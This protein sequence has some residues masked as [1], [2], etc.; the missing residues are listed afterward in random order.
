[1]THAASLALS[2]AH[3]YSNCRP[4]IHASCTAGG[5]PRERVRR[6]VRV[7]IPHRRHPN[8]HQDTGPGP[9]EGLPMIPALY[10]QWK[11]ELRF[12]DWTPC[13]KLCI[14]A[15]SRNWRYA[16]SHRLKGP[17][18]FRCTDDAAAIN[19]QV[20]H[21]QSCAVPHQHCLSSSM[22]TL[23]RLPIPLRKLPNQS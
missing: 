18:I 14:F 8:R 20:M 2:G 16:F 21:L 12:S 13:H 11:P 7:E 1:M 19:D 6:R 4:T 3:I 10:L 17:M 22:D 23:K 9:Q 15:E 5:C